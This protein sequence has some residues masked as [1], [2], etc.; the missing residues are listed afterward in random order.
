[1]RLGICHQ[2][3]LPG[4]WEDAIATAGQLGVE[5]IELFVRPEDIEGFLESPEVARSLKAAA[6]RAGV[7]ISS[8]GLIFSFRGEAKLSDPATRQAA[9]AQVANGI[10]RCADAGGDVVLV[11][12]VPAPEEAAAMDA[13]VASVRELVPV[14][15][16]HGIR[17]GLE[18][19]LGSADVLA[20]LDRV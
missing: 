14:A 13:Y 10:R 8:L 17:I 3:S 7:R 5:G 1:M 20:M 11:G 19:G 9:V 15:R 6:E 18:C 4:A 12:G 16:E 2:V